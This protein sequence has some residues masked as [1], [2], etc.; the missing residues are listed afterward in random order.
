MTE[1]ITSP[2]TATGQL[3]SQF[4]CDVSAQCKVYI[5]WRRKCSVSLEQVSVSRLYPFGL[6]EEEAALTRSFYPAPPP[7][8]PGGVGS[9]SILAVTHTHTDGWITQKRVYT[10]TRIKCCSSICV[11]R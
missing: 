11:R 10:C 2:R 7:S 3:L 6:Q 1:N 5:F 8:C 4:G 9:K